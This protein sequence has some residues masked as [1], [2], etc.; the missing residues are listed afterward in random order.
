MNKSSFAIKGKNT[1]TFTFQDKNISMLSYIPQSVKLRLAKTYVDLMFGAGNLIDNYFSA[2]WSI[3]I[4]LVEDCTNI[5]VTQLDS[6]K[7]VD[8]ETLT[9]SGLWDEI[10]SRL[11]DYEDF[12]KDLDLIFKAVSDKLISDKSIENTFDRIGN[13]VIEFLEKISSLDVSEDGV[14]KLIEALNVQVERFKKDFP[15]SE[16]TPD[17]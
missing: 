16:V 4:G 15:T 6:N 3:I 12:R 2:E 5:E 17:K 10:K 1:T 8:L 13:G 14:S 7:N 9:S 11:K